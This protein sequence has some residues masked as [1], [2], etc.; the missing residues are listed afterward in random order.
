MR[1]PDRKHRPASPARVALVG[2]VA[3]APIRCEGR[4]GYK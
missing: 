2:E 1:T 4:R 3:V